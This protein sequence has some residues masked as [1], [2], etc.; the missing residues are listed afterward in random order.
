MSLGYCP[1]GRHPMDPGWDVC[2]YCASESAKNKKGDATYRSTGEDATGESAPPAVL[3]SPASNPNRTVFG[4][5]ETAP[6]RVVGVLVTYTWRP[7]G[8]LFPV[9][10]GSNFLGSAPECEARVTEDPRMSGRHASI[11]YRPGG[12]WIDDEKSM[13]G[14]FV[15]GDPV[16]EKQRLPVSAV[17]RTGGTVWRFAALEPPSET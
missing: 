3:A 11:V 9:R 16:E 15:D 5:E 2:P 10:E 12:F 14:T 6:R 8:E 7:E 17:I 13:N 1:A 4:G